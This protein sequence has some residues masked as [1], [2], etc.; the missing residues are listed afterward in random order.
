MIKLLKTEAHGTIPECLQPKILACPAWASA[1]LQ[2]RRGRSP[3]LVSGG[4]TL[5]SRAFGPALA[6]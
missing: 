5:S 3:E 1:P 4:I 2:E 6:G